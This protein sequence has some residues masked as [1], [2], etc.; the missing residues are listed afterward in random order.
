MKL[1]YTSLIPGYKFTQQET[2][3]RLIYKGNSTSLSETE[4]DANMRLQPI[5]P[6]NEMSG[7]IVEKTSISLAK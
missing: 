5:K 4:M 2:H 6:D 1:A 7:G 3:S